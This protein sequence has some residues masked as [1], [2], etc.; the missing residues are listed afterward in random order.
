MNA[1]LLEMLSGWEQGWLSTPLSVLHEKWG[2]TG[3]SPA[4]LSG[5]TGARSILL[6]SIKLKR[7]SY[8]L[9]VLLFVH[10]AVFIFQ[11]LLSSPYPLCQWLRCWCCCGLWHLEA[12]LRAS[13]WCAGNIRV[14]IEPQCPLKKIPVVPCSHL[15]SPALQQKPYNECEA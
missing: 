10:F 5:S 1:V 11:C 14:V 6:C 2:I 3:V 12:R 9:S 8:L 7:F 13:W 4:P 15:K